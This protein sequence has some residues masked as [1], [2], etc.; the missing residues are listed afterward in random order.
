MYTVHSLFD[1]PLG[2]GEIIVVQRLRR[3]GIWLA[4]ALL[5]VAMLYLARYGVVRW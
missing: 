3:I 4:A 2:F 1:D 5:C